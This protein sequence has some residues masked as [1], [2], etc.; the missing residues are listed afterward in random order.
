MPFFI[1]I[2]LSPWVDTGEMGPFQNS[3]A[4]PP[5]ERVT[6][7]YLGNVE[8]LAMFQ[9]IPYISLQRSGYCEHSE[10]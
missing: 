8:N 2:F 6:M 5:N 4:S 7:I 10:I 9:L 1:P 3:S